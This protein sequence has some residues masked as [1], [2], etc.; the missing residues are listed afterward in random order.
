MAGLP[1]DFTAW[2]GLNR[3]LDWL[4]VVATKP[5]VAALR[6][7]FCRG[8]QGVQYGTG[9]WHHPLL[10]LGE[11]Q[12]FLV[13]DRDGVGVNLEEVEFGENVGIKLE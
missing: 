13:V 6:G 3:R 1:R 11:P 2:R 9:V 8:D 4:V 5:E 12:D 7:F 10:V